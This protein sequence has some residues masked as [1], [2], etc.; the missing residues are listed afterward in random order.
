MKKSDNNEN[1]YAKWL[2]G[3][4]TEE[5]YNQLK[6]TGDLEVLTELRDGLDELF[7][8]SVD[9][10]DIDVSDYKPHLEL[11]K[12][13][14]KLASKP[15]VTPLKGTKYKNWLRIAAVLVPL[16]AFALYYIVKPKN[17][18]I[19]TTPVAVKTSAE[20]PDG[21]IVGLNSK[22]EIKYKDTYYA[23]RVE[24]EGEAF[25]EVKHDEKPFIVETKLGEVEVLGT[26]FNVFS[27][28][29]KFRVICNEGK[30]KVSNHLKSLTLTKGERAIFDNPNEPIK[31][32]V[33][34][35]Y[36]PWRNGV[37]YLEGF[38]VDEVIDEIERQFDVDI[39]TENIDTSDLLNIVLKN[40]DGLE[41]VLDDFVYTINCTYQINNNTILI[42]PK[43]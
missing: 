12:F 32:E 41:N 20:L 14:K 42:K 10:V 38:S 30:V 5:E 31:D 1:I 25:F 27:R 2:D 11:E 18:F 6:E 22:S 29:N 36:S 19:K 33:G 7:N 8:S 35:D 37:S 16:F 15:K 9:E 23:R 17:N 24:L 3:K 39:K 34:I 28:N 40:N 4:L 13:K 26:S 21:S 43:D